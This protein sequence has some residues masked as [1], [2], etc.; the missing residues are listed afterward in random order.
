MIKLSTKTND[1]DIDKTDLINEKNCSSSDS[2]G[3]S[4]N[5][6]HIGTRPHH[7]TN[8]I[9][10]NV[11]EKLFEEELNTNK[12]KQDISNQ[13]NN[14]FNLDDKI[15]PNNSNVKVQAKPNQFKSPSKR[16]QTAKS[17][18]NVVPKSLFNIIKEDK[19][20]MNDNVISYRRKSTILEV[21]EARNL[22]NIR[23]DEK[24]D[25]Y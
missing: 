10:S 24:E 3:S 19:K 17:L 5:E 4:P 9:K 21:L 16:F 1:N 11:K 14:Q 13:D 6:K 20:D 15:D 23:E 22:P 2:E 12:D 18:I 7:C 8:E 25:K